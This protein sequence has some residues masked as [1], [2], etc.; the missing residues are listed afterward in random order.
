MGRTCRW[1]MWR[2]LERSAI[3]DGMILKSAGVFAV[4]VGFRYLLGFSSEHRI[5]TAIPTL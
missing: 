2:L 1:R 4:G 5:F 3:Y